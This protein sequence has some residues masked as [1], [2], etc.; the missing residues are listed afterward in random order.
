MLKKWLR[1]CHAKRVSK[2]NLERSE[3]ET[4]TVSKVSIMRKKSEI[5]TMTVSKVS[6]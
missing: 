4:M 1:P 5:E 2:L 3:V 6:K